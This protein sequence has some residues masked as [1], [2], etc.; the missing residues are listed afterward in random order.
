MLIFV[1]AIGWALG[2]PGNQREASLR[3]T[4]NSEAAL[5]MPSGLASISSTTLPWN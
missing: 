4:E 5:L 2:A 3:I 1:L